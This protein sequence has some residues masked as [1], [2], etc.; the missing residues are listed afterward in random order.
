MGTVNANSEE[1]TG[2]HRGSQVILPRI[3]IT[4][5]EADLPFVMIRRQL[6][7][8]L[9]YAMTINKA[10]GQSLRRVGIYLR[11]PVFSHLQMY[12]AI[13]RAGIPCYGRPGALLSHWPDYTE[14]KKE[15]TILFLQNM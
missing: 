11:H 6:P 14:K 7:I 13:S 3:N 5:S 10:Q 1:V 12:T 2:S 8:R 4:T 9:A 15:K